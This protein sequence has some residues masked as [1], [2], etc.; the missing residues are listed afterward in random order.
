VLVMAMLVALAIAVYDKRFV[1]SV[2]VAVRSARS[3]LQLPVNGDVRMRGTIIGRVTGVEQSGGG[4]T[5]SLALHPRDARLVPAN[6]RARILPTT[7][8]GQ[9]YVELVAPP[10]PSPA[11][12]AAGATLKEDTSQETAEVT[13]VLDHLVPLLRAVRPQELSATLQ[14]LADGLEGRGE[15]L[16]RTAELAHE[17]LSQLNLD[18]PGLAA[19]LRLLAVV[20]KSYASATP[21]IL[22][23]LDHA[24]V[25]GTTILDS[26]HELDVFYRELTR[27]ARI[28]RTYLD[29]NADGIVRLTSTTRPVLELLGTYS[30]EFPCLFQGLLRAE[31]A[32]GQA[33]RD[34]VFHA[35]V[36]LGRQY[37]GYT[38]ADLPQ[39]GDLGA[40][41][42]CAGLPDVVPPV[43][44]THSHDGADY[45]PGHLLRR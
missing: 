40:G 36:A 25:T 20:S 19:D 13:K 2:D 29:R 33:F 11:P 28:T 1:A 4:V 22:V 14:A 45:P 42:H 37:P 7:L 23:T 38:A 12:V 16:G 30:P 26:R 27:F 41:P 15:Q 5:I 44:S 6:A 8:F 34:G 3:G 24:T 31:S 21:A 32:A 39:F 10:H 43:P 35:D 18:L 9:K 17:Y